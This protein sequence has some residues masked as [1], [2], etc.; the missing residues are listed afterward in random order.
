MRERSVRS[1]CCLLVG[2]IA[3]AGGCGAEGPA[4]TGA[5][6]GAAAGGAAGSGGAG[7][8]TTVQTT[9]TVVT[10]GEGAGAPLTPAFEV[11]GVVVDQD[12]APVEGAYVLQG[13]RSGEEPW[14]VTG[15]DGAFTIEI[16][17]GGLG[18][19]TVVASKT[20]YR[21]AGFEF[22]WLPTRPVT[23]TLY[24]ANPPDNLAYEYQEPGV[25]DDPSTK[26]CG[27]CHVSFAKQFQ[28]SKHAQA[29]KNPQ[30]QDLYA[31]VSRAHPDQASCQAAGGKWS[32]GLVPGTA[33]DYAFKCYLGGGVLPD[34][35]ESCGGPGQSQ[36]DGAGLP[37]GE[38]PKAFGGCADCHAPGIDGPAGGRNLHEAVGIAFDNGVHCDPCHKTA[39]VDL[40]KPPGVGQ[41]LATRRPT[42]THDGTPGGKLRA[43]FYGPLV[44]VPNPAMGGG[45]QPKFATAVLCAGCHEQAQPALV[46][47]T[48]LDATKWPNGLPVHTTYGEWLAGPYPKAGAH[49]QFCHMPEDHSIV[50]G[51]D[52]ATL[53]NASI[54]FGFPRPPSQLRQHIFRSPL[55]GSPRLI[56][57]ALSI[58]TELVVVGGTVLDA[59][60][61]LSNTGCGHAVPTGDP[62][63]ALVLLVRARCGATALAATGGMT[64][65]DAGGARARGVVGTDVTANGAVLDWAAGAAIAKAGALVRAVRPTGA[66]DDYAATGAFAKLTPAEK[67]LP[68]LEPLGE[69]AVVGAAGGQVTLAGALALQAGD[70]VWLGDALAQPTDGAGSVALA[71]A[72][73]YAFAKVLLDAAGAR[74]VPHYRAVDIASDNRIPPGAYAKTRHVFALAPGCTDAELEATVLYRP[75]PLALA[76]ERGWS[77]KDYLIA[78]ATKSITIP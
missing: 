52:H 20:G 13:G 71:G 75:L 64:V 55:H 51:D 3:A 58:A 74:G 10:T 36:C 25:G 21:T 60:V 61:S 66:F 19:P 9:S 57:G 34:L 29:T 77:A 5:Q 26:Y 46:P 54:T 37:L 28:T 63:R 27:H 40:A 56:D 67:G 38:Q 76:E 65:F 22:E 43:V 17:Y 7:P 30:L 41:R 4:G 50:T 45:Y 33:G 1:A 35:N 69:A 53:A 31:G 32:L 59:T 24:A 16:L 62:M 18:V 15:A 73:G 39:D 72:A 68:I 70:V 8:T 49:C 23:L 6:A 12:G 14:L 78:K 44:D 42:E 47:G 48:S 11:T 2:A